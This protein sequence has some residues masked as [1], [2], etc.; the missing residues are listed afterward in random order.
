MGTKSA[1]REVL[2]EGD[3]IA[4]ACCA[5]LLTDAA[6]PCVLAKAPRPT[7]AAVLL[8]EQTQHLLRE[9][10]PASSPEDDLFAGFAA[11]RRRIVRWGF[12]EQAIELPH[13][14]LVVP[15]AELLRR[16]WRRVPH[17]PAAATQKE[18]WKIL[19]SRG[20]VPAAVELRCGS[21]QAHL[22]PVELVD[23]AEDQAC[24]VES[25]SNGWLFLLSLGDGTASFFCVADAIE[26]ALNESTLV[27]SRIRKRPEEYTQASA[28]PRILLLLASSQW[29]SCGT[30]AM[31]FDPLCGEGTGNAVR[32]AILAAAVVQSALSGDAAEP[33]VEHYTSRLQQGFLR[34]LQIC[35][36][37]YA[38]GGKGTF[39][40]TECAALR[41]GIRTLEAAL[42]LQSSPRYRLV[43]RTLLPI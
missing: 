14:G 23:D 7:L 17:L 10:F 34:H 27:A 25:V 37:F 8:G 29:L 20:G 39:W 30:A 11:I 3:G 31:T 9:L 19:S 28:Y 4:A 36:Q 6:I 21:R 32:E 42:Q 41:E 18:G 15:E 43:D 16:L 38:S 40:E 22:A 1:A 5:R 33:L 35:L 12:A 13:Y 24:W 2:I 26:P